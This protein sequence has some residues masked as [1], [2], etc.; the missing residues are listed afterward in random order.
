V[1]EVRIRLRSIELREVAVPLVRPFRTSFGEERE[2]RAILVRAVADEAVGWGE[3]VAGET[4]RYSAEWLDGAWASISR[5]LAPSA[6][7]G[8]PVERPEDVGARMAWARGHRMAKAAVESA[9]LDCW[10]RA[11]GLPLSAFLGGVRD[12]VECGVSVGIAPSVEA[13]LEEIRG[14]LAKGYRRVKLKIEPGRDVG[15]VRRI[16][17]ELP[18]TPL[19]VDANAAYSPADAPVFQ[20]LDELGLV[21]IEQPLDHEDLVEHARLQA[22][23]GTSICLDESIRSAADARAAIDMGACRIIN[24]KPGRV[25]GPLEARRV[26]D[27]AAASSVPAWIGGMLETGVGRALNVA[28]ATLPGV[29]MPGDTSASERYFAEDLTEPFVVDADGTMAVPTGP[30]IGVEPLAERLAEC[31]VRTETIT[32]SRES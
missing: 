32:P 1:S 26:H 3:C 17:D 20:A 27:A 9:V 5:F 28:M 22:R 6:L 23:L 21:M 19:S 2:K 10:L 30:G 8:G 14:Y 24:I 12:R 4:P 29:T 7:D 13:M 15:V 18:D 11:A 16:R 25:G 31:T